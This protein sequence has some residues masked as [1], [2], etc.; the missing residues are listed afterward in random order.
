MELWDAYDRQLQ[1]IEGLTLVRGEPVP[2]GTFHLVCDVIVRHTDGAYL[3]MQRD[4]RKHYGGLWEATAGGSAL[5]GETP[6]E[7]AVRELRE[8]TGIV[9]SDLT[10]VG[11]IVD[12]STIYVEFLCETDWPK[13]RITLQ[14]G[15]T[16]AFRWVDRL[17]LLNMKRDEL[18][19]E[20][21]QRFIDELRTA[22]QPTIIL[23]RDHPDMME[24]KAQWFHEKWGIAE[25]AYRESM[26]ACLK[27]ASPVPQWYVM[28]D[29]DRIVG[30]LGVIDN[31]FHE[32]PDLTPNVCAV[33]TM[34]DCRGRGIAGRLLNAA[35]ED[36]H[37]FGIDVLYLLTDHD[38]FYERYGWEYLCPVR[39]MDETTDSRMYIHRYGTK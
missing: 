5:K 9:C 3:L 36:M 30:G 21:M 2:A 8:E 18:I 32:R 25:E 28:T 17:T 38:S 6:I 33:Y 13:D 15:E 11:T 39:G 37:G 34:P 12:E 35:C 10:E 23:L 14:E 31:D 19:T 4:P 22:Q 1:K 29:G 20:R 24:R 27:G 16:V 7:C 26:E